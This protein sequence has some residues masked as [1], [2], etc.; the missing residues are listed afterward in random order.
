MIRWNRKKGYYETVT[1][2]EFADYYRLYKSVARAAAVLDKENPNNT[3]GVINCLRSVYNELKAA[4][5]GAEVIEVRER[6]R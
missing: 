6:Y 1:V 2:L 5:F 3:E 4:G